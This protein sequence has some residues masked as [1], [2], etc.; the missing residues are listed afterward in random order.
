M[1]NSS[2]RDSTMSPTIQLTLRITTSYGSYENF[3]TKFRQWAQPYL[4]SGYKV[5][6][7]NQTRKYL[8][9]GPKVITV[10]LIKT[11]KN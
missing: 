6:K 3:T 8:L 9:V 1:A 2:K 5:H 4:D 11:I 7:I 10:S